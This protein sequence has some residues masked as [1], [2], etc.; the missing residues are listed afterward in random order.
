MAN[1]YGGLLPTVIIKGNR[2]VKIK[3]LLFYLRF[4]NPSGPIDRLLGAVWIPFVS[5]RAVVTNSV[6]GLNNTHLLSK[7]WRLNHQDQVL[8]WPS[9]R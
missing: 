2:A 5:V 4:T 7:F 6:G 1:D 9:N 3:M 8:V